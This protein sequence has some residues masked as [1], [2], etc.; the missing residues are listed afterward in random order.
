MQAERCETGPL[1]T[2]D[3]PLYHE[4]VVRFEF[5][6]NLA[7]LNLKAEVLRDFYFGF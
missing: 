5:R 2:L 4:L 3:K 1:S 7:H 6:V